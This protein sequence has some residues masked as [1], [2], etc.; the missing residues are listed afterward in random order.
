MPLQTRSLEKQTPELLG[1]LRPTLLVDSSVVSYI[2]LI[3][4]Q[5]F[6]R[7]IRTQLAC[8]LNELFELFEAFKI[9]DRVDKNNYV[10]RVRVFIF[11]V[12]SFRKTIYYFENELPRIA[13]VVRLG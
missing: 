3:A 12:V 4:H 1:Q 8:C 10:W 2:A 9:V 5:N 13:F 11:R 6:Q 7:F